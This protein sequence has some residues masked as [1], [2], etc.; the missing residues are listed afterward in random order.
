MRSKHSVRLI[1]KNFAFAKDADRALAIGT[2]RGRARRIRENR[3]GGL[4]SRS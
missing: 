3:C 4:D 1:R 2:V